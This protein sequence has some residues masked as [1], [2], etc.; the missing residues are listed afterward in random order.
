MFLR[1]TKQDSKQHAL[2][3]FVIKYETTQQKRCTLLLG[4]SFSSRLLS[5]V[6]STTFLLYKI[7]S[8]RKIFS[9]SKNYIVNLLTL[10]IFY[11][12]KD[13]GG[14]TNQTYLSHSTAICCIQRLVVKSTSCVHLGI[15]YSKKSQIL[16][17]KYLQ[18]RGYTC[19]HVLSE[20]RWH[21]WCPLTWNEHVFVLA[22]NRSL[23]DMPF[24]FNKEGC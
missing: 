9:V 13:V 16:Q 3:F 6:F 10:K 19:I 20:I 14:T 1:S 8:V 17:Q 15:N 5:A 22:I 21:R 18:C 12:K 23:L 2:P 24:N 11:S 7:F 4:T